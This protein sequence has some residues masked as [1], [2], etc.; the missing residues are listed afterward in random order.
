MPCPECGCLGVEV[1]KEQPPL[2]PRPLVAKDV[3]YV[4][5]D[6]MRGTI[7]KE[8][9]AMAIP[10]PELDTG[11]SEL[12][13]FLKPNHLNKKGRTKIIVTGNVRE[14]SGTF[15][16][17]LNL[18]VKMGTKAYTL[19]VKLNSPNHRLLFARFGKNENKWKGAIQVERGE[20]LGKEYIKVC[21]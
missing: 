19:S 17:Q 6:G 8:K 12:P 2:F 1:I 3:I 18:D 5:R 13:P 11:K 14:S 15:G 9:N 7:K 4:G 20:Y 16:A 21:E 10:A